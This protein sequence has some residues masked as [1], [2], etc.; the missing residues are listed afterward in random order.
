M[1][2][3][4]ESLGGESGKNMQKRYGMGNVTKSSNFTT[5]TGRGEKGGQNKGSF[6][7]NTEILGQ[8]KTNEQGGMGML[9][10]SGIVND[11]YM[12]TH[13]HTSHKHTHTQTHIHTY[14]YKTYKTYLYI[15]Y[16]VYI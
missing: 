8:T 7:P 1:P 13:T 14:M 9:S 6:W 3:T 5:S 15:Y 11:I 4:L 10:K 2:K 12:H 16:N